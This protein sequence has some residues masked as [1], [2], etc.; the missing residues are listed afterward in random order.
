MHGKHAVQIG[1]AIVVIICAHVSR[2]VAY[3]T[4]Q[5]HP[6]NAS[7]LSSQ[8][9]APKDTDYFMIKLTPTGV[10]FTTT[11]AV[12]ADKSV[13]SKTG[14]NALTYEQFWDAQPDSKADDPQAQWQSYL[15]RVNEEM[16]T[17]WAGHAHCAENGYDGFDETKRNKKAPDLLLKTGGLLWGSYGVAWL[18]AV[19]LGLPGIPGCEK[20]DLFSTHFGAFI[21]FLL[22]SAYLMLSI[23]ALRLNV[24]VVNCIQWSYADSGMDIEPYADSGNN[25]YTPTGI[26]DRSRVPWANLVASI[27]VF[28]WAGFRVFKFR[29]EDDMEISG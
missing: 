4:F 21:G 19:V 18:V 6:T 7:P 15:P 27:I 8:V 29:T 23:Y 13:L 11:Y 20:A 1:A 22:F 24:R 5:Y 3:P 2:F 25:G 12:N 17:V 10:E 16:N 28:I 9:T 14:K 26:Y